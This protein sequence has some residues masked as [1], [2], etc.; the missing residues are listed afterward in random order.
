ME[1][2]KNLNFSII[3]FSQSPGPRYCCQGDDSGELFYHNILNKEFAKAYRADVKLVV[4]LDGTDGYAS[5]FLDEAF[6]NLV[7]DF[8]AK[9][10]KTHIDIVSNDEDVWKEMIENETIPE[11]EKR[12]ISN[13]QPRKT[14]KHGKWFRIIDGELKEDIWN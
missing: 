5:S 7:Y 3:D 14:E 11:W 8:S 4:I 1:Q 12:R 9:I 6:G 2:Q 10:V 13:L